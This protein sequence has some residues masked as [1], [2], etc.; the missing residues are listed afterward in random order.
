MH[1]FQPRVH[2]VLLDGRHVGPVNDLSKVRGQMFVPTST[3]CR[4]ATRPGFSPKQFSLQSPPTRTSWYSHIC[5]HLCE[6]QIYA[7][8]NII[9]SS[10]FK[11]LQMIVSSD[12]KAEDRQQPVCERLP[13]LLQVF[14]FGKSSPS[15]KD[16]FTTKHF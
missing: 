12:Y 1:K 13:G 8:Q 9:K 2:L 7:D 14:F 6:L 16:K 10:G 11:D 5:L 15:L 4:S 3:Q